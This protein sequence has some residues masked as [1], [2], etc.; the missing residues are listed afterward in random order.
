[1]VTI[2]GL[3]WAGMVLK[4]GKSGVYHKLQIMKFYLGGL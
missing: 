1:M 2:Y 4:T 3:V